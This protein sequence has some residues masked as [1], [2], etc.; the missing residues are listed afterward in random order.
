[1][2]EAFFP[3]GSAEVRIEPARPED[4]HAILA[5]AADTAPEEMPFLRAWWDRVP[6]A[7]SAVRDAGGGVVGFHI[8]CEAGG[9]DPLL[10]DEDPLTAA[11]FEHL[12][13]EP[14]PDG[15]LV[16]FYRRWLGASVGEDPSPAQGAC[17]LDIKRSYMEMRPH[18]R[19]AYMAVGDL[20][21]FSS[22][23]AALGIR[24]RPEADVDVGGTILHTFVLEFGA[25][26]VD[27]WLRRLVGAELGAVIDDDEVGGT[28]PEGTVT[29][30][31]ADIADSTALTERVGDERFRSLARVLDG[32]VRDVIGET[33]GVPIEGRL[34][35]DGLMAVFPL[36]HQAVECAVRTNEAAA[37]TGLGL[38]V[39]LHAGDV[40]RED[41]NVFG[42]AVNIAARVAA[43]APPGEVLVSET[44]RSLARTS[45][46]VTF[47]GR[48]YHDLKGVADRYPLY[49]VTGSR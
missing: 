45:T 43:M 21:I 41:A 4:A 42:G 13:R 8:L 12:R 18:L 33:G 11:W 36:A 44:V 35:G 25:A 40:I 46:T 47:E 7:F 24:H 6:D 48:G 28:V 34:L 31:F 32:S 29:I 22:A 2:R 26:S 27:G 38:H 16:L 23:F 9:A 37:E 30:M 39:G 10:A 3:A 1:V 14:V 17:F 20:D 5:I 15:G 49:A 19:R